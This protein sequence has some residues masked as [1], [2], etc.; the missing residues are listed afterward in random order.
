MTVIVIFLLIIIAI[1]GYDLWEDF[2]TWLGRIKIG[3]L[4]DSEWHD[5]TRKILLKWISKGTP[6]VLINDNKKS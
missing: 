1:L 6:E 2:L 3:R 4:T 5:K